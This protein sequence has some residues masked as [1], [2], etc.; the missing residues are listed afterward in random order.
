MSVFVLFRN[1]S[2][3]DVI[4]GHSLVGSHACGPPI[5]Q[6][7]LSYQNFKPISLTVGEF[8]KRY[9]QNEQ[10]CKLRGGLLVVS[11]QANFVCVIIF[12][13]IKVP[14]YT[15]YMKCIFQDFLV[16]PVQHSHPQQLKF[17]M[18]AYL[19]LVLITIIRNQKVN[20]NFWS[21]RYEFYDVPIEPPKNP[22]LLCSTE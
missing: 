15:V 17:W 11:C 8:W 20:V 10:L 4:C 16:D 21:K 19:D 7:L 18:L 5:F 14:S 9:H 13:F 22:Q 12:R 1:F 3:I 2:G 6:I